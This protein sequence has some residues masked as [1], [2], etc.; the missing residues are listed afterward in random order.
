[1]TQEMPNENRPGTRQDDAVFRDGVVERDFSFV[2][3]LKDHRASKGLR[4]RREMKHGRVG[5]RAA[6]GTGAERAAPHD[7]LIPDD[8][9]AHRLNVPVAAQSLETSAKVFD[10]D[11]GLR[12]RRRA[13]AS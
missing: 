2:N 13:A 3:Q 5:D 11:G 4:Q 8:D 7:R 12:Y 6:G 10:G 1:M 9:R